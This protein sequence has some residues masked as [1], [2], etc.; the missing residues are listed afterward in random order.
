MSKAQEKFILTIARKRITEAGNIGKEK[1]Y[2]VV[3]GFGKQG[4]VDYCKGIRD[5]VWAIDELIEDVE[6]QDGD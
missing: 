6:R 3:D 4:W 1:R 2:H 5:A